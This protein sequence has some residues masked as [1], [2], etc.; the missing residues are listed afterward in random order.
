M[1]SALKLRTTNK[2]K[3]IKIGIMTKKLALFIIALC[4]AI[5][6]QAQNS[7]QARAILDKTAAVVG[8][9]GGAQ[10]NFT[11]QNAKTGTTSG[12]IAI[13]GN[14]FHASTPQAIVWYNGKTQWTYLKQNEEVN[15]TTPSKAKQAAM[16]PYAFINLYKSG[17][18][19]TMSTSGGLHTVHMK[20]TN[21]ASKSI[22]EMYITINKQTYVPTQV[23]M[24]HGS[25][26][27]TITIKNFKAKT[28][29]DA[30]FT[31]NAKDFPSAEVVDLR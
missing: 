15:I 30:T 26:W 18:T 7:T 9:K 4:S 27:T 13:K 11:M 3:L 1:P 14:K 17:Y 19:L 2:V 8:N 25:A 24:R 29:S 31:F 16:N 6:L 10:A 20:A 5:A 23:K 12:T 22:P 28:L 21:A